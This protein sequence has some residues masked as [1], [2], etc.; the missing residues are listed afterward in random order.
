MVVDYVFGLQ[1]LVV[2]GEVDDGSDQPG[3]M[4]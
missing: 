3:L 4:D 2:W 1:E